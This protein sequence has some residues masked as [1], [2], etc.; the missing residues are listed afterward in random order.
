MARAYLAMLWY[1]RGVVR[2][3]DYL[4][5]DQLRFLTDESANRLV[6]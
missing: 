6:A 2:S 5:D 4:I 3:N 1:D